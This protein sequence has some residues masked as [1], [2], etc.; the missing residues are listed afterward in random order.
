MVYVDTSV[1]VALLTVEPK[2]REVTAWYAGLREV[3]YCADWLLTEFSSALS[4][5]VRT[6]QLTE[7]QAKLVRKEFSLL[8]AGGIRLVPV[9]RAAFKQAADLVKPYRFGL[10]AGDSLHLAVALE[11]GIRHIA[12]LDG[13]LAKNAERKGLNPIM[14]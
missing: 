3:P 4:I 14:L 1:L 11:L 13:T 7:T 2:T 8:T 6:R 9:S 5:K 10:R 12:T